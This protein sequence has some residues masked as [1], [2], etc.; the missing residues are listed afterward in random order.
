MAPK[1][2]RIH[3][4]ACL[5]SP[6][7]IYTLGQTRN[8]AEDGK[9]TV[10]MWNASPRTVLFFLWIPAPNGCI[11]PV[12]QYCLNKLKLFETETMRIP[13]VLLARCDPH[14]HYEGRSFSRV[15]IHRS[16]SG[17]LLP[18]ELL[19]ASETASSDLGEQFSGLRYKTASWAI[20][21]A[22][23]R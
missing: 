22:L 3:A 19:R 15:M 8:A 21:E 9:S 6:R 18:C 16:R 7:L 13:S 23:C 2:M 1:L 17:E 12:R 20:R 14:C 5:L 10:F 11:I 4:P